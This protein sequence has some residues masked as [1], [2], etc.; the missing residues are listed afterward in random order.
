MRRLRHLLAFAAIVAVS[1]VG[2]SGSQ[3]AVTAVVGEVFTI[4]VGQSARITGEDMVIKFDEVVGDSRCPQGVTCIWEGQA[5]SRVTI[6]YQGADYPMVLTLLGSADETKASFVRYTL[7]Y[8][9][10]PYPVQGKKISPKDY[11]LTLTV[12]K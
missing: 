3:I 6:S 8:S 5:S 12:T 1:L 11:R 9:L 4:G 10:K 2:C 7:T